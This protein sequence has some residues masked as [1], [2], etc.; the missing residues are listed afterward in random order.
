MYA[1]MRSQ[2][3]GGGGVQRGLRPSERRHHLHTVTVSREAA[4]APLKDLQI[5]RK[6]FG[7]RFGDEERLPDPS[8]A[9]GR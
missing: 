9:S 4:S 1:N 5:L 7:G 2:P 8:P 3:R 6:S